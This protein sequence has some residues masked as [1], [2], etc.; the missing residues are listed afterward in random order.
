M[1]PDRTPTAHLLAILADIGVE[2]ALVGSM[3][4]S[5][6]GEPRATQDIDIL[7]RFNRSQLELLP[8]RLEGEFYFDLETAT[9][10]LRL[11]RSFNV[12]SFREVLKF[13]LFPAQADEFGPTQLARKVIAKLSAVSEEGIPVAS[14]EDTILAKLRWFHQ[15]GRTSEKQWND[16]LGVIRVQAARLDWPYIESWAPRLGVADLLARLPRPH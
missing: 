3:A 8:A 2:F 14:P 16:I 5:A 9:E 10:A 15:T 1:I 12:I 6:H 4:S 7:A 11:G 13:D